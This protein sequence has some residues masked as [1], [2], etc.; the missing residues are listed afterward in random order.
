MKIPRMLS[1]ERTG[2]LNVILSALLF[3]F[4]PVIVKLGGAIPPIF[5]AGLSTLITA[6]LMMLF[7][8]YKGVFS[9]LKNKKA[10]KYIFL[11]TLFVIIIPY[12]L[13]YKG[14]GMTSGINASILFQAEIFFAMF[15]GWI[16]GEAITERKILGA[17]LIIAG[18]FFVLFNGTLKFNFGDLLIIIGTAFYPVANI[19]AKKAL[20][21]ISPITLVFARSAIGGITLLILSL[22]P[23]GATV[24]FPII[25]GY[26]WLFA[27]NGLVVSG[28]TKV[29]WY[30]GLETMDVSKATILI[31]PYPAF[32]VIY[33]GAFLGEI[34]T[35]YQ[36]AGLIIVILGV[37]TMVNHKK[38]AVH[39]INLS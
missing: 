33:A 30:E 2:E 22:L 34:P 7:M 5:F 1:R 4:F 21:I 24:S 38:K 14:I 12:L 13:I 29:L 35:L 23:E 20:K 37:Y 25:A 17:T 10:W 3:A 6:L 27:I 19:Y 16:I 8:A 15:Y 36:L 32:G 26:W 11:V 18:T 31:M 28:I 39:F 9:E